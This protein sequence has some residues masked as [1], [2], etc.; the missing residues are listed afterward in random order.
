MYI[1]KNAL[2]NVK[3]NMS[4]NVLLLIILL[5]VI[6]GSVVAL[7][8]KS[9]TTLITEEYRNSIG[10]QAT[11]ELDESKF[12][13]NGKKPMVI[14]MDQYRTLSESEFVR[15]YKLSISMPAEGVGIHGKDAEDPN[16]EKTMGMVG[17]DENGEGVDFDTLP[18]L[19]LLGAIGTDGPAFA[20]FKSGRRSITDGRNVEKDGE[21]LISEEL[22]DINNLKVGD[23]IKLSNPAR[24]NGSVLELKVVGI[25]KD[26]TKEYPPTIFTSAYMNKRNE[27]LTTFDTTRDFY[28][29]QSA[30]INSEFAL[31]SPEDLEAFTKLAR[32]IGITDDYLIKVDETSYAK[33]VGPLETLDSI[34]T[35]FIIVMLA[36]ATGVILLLSVL[37][38]RERQYE[39]GVLRAMG[40]KKISI[41]IGFIFES[42]SLLVVSLVLGVAIGSMIS[43]PVANNL[44][45]NQLD[46]L[47]SAA[48]PADM[49]S[50]SKGVKDNKEEVD[51][52][53]TINTNTDFIV[54][55][56]IAGIGLI[57]VLV[58]N[59]VAISYIMKFEPMDI[60]RKRD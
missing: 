52:I 31:R 51:V 21:A 15:T 3:R 19:K 22:A 2:K 47:N 54:I 35:Y 39:I 38:I 17:V 24:P 11:I 53:D 33:A 12:K 10:A 36:V 25:Y 7:S 56:Q 5:L 59:L 37:S 29:T 13:G 42:I 1:I 45:Q 48:S 43:N 18:S 58:S 14:T 44:L 16:K 49:Q 6:V 41:A 26:L 20:D 40:M 27:I 32:E 46:N 23:V 57:L 50:L 28:N 9:A 60:M 30:T 34:M 55:I 8:I 4:R